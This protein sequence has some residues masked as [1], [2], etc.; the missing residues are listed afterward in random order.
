MV[1][2]AW[3][4][5]LPLSSRAGLQLMAAALFHGVPFHREMRPRQK[6]DADD[7]EELQ[8]RC[9][10]LTEELWRY[11]TLEDLWL[12]KF[13][14]LIQLKP[15]TANGVLMPVSSRQCFN[16]GRWA[17]I[18]D[19]SFTTRE[20]YSNPRL[21]FFLE[22]PKSAHSPPVDSSTP[23]SANRDLVRLQLFPSMLLYAMQEFWEVAGQFHAEDL[24]RG[25]TPSQIEPR[26][27]IPRT[28][29]EIG[30][31]NLKAAPPMVPKKRGRRAGSGYDDAAWG[32]AKEAWLIRD[33]YNVAKTEAYRQALLGF[34]LVKPR[35]SGETGL[36]V[37]FR[38]NKDTEEGSAMKRVL[39]MLD[40]LEALHPPRF[41]RRTDE[42]LGAKSAMW[43]R[44][45][46]DV[47]ARVLDML[48]RL[49]D[50]LADQG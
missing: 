12:D 15:S 44:I 14:D 20:L 36:P 26:N 50:P 33:S 42:Y 18:S 23:I 35:T 25:V 49:E 38:S 32:L 2:K 3:E 7:L 16:S 24:R 43:R 27:S 21:S 40:K 34:E 29:A 47:N 1:V 28:E 46:A 11:D 5:R 22:G 4:E 19:F 41:G 9:P 45:E 13:N 31:W 48:S 30:F 10:F 8:K 37:V 39:S 17:L 6:D